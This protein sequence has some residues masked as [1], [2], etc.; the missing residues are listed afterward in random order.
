MPP[1][2][3]KTNGDKPQKIEW[4][5]QGKI[6]NKIEQTPK[7]SFAFIYKITLLDGTGRYYI[8]KKYMY[9][10]KYTSGAKKGQYKGVYPWQSYISSS[11]ELKALIKSGIPYKKEILFFTYSKAE[12]TYKE[13]AE[14]LCG[15]HLTNPNCL[16]YWVKATIYSKHL[17]ENS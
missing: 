1:K 10:P 13:T 2:K 12:T 15:Q 17:K 5:Y 14:I 7:D 9:K 4:E 3:T 6:I 16:N 8:G 11:V